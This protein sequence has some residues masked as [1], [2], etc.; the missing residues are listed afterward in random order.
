MKKPLNSLSTFFLFILFLN[1]SPAN[2]LSE[3]VVS[4]APSITE[5]I[6]LLG[7]EDKIVG[8][9][10]YCEHP[11]GA[12]NKE[13][14]GTILK[15]SIEKIVSL[16]PDLVLATET[17]TPR[18]I[19]KIRSLGIKIIVFPL[20]ENFS[21][22]CANFIKLG[23][24]LG[25]KKKAI[26]IVTESKHKVK[27]IK[28]MVKDLEKPKVFWEV[29]A[30]PLIT[31][32]KDSFPDEIIRLA[33]GI[34]IAHNLPIG[35]IRYSREEVIKQNPD[36]II[37]VTEGDITDKEIKHWKNYKKLKA[38]KLNRIYVIDAHIVCSPVPSTFVLGLERTAELL[39]PESFKNE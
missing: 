32:A 20:E 7:K 14:I 4:L 13:K 37:L 12:K 30:A 5:S 10:V 31:V 33:G 17:N 35:Y 27:L 11:P 29:G 36:V 18:T 8:V 25:K 26:E 19:K 16:R 22:I 1:I 34:N 39:H 9:T 15:P 28:K 24:K 6:Y 2:A 38:A 21:D 23:K 3:R